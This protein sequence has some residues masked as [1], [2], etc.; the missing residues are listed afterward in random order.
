[1]QIE[2][3]AARL[4]KA[5]AEQSAAANAHAER[6][7]LAEVLGLRAE[8]LGVR[9]E[10]EQLQQMY[11]SVS[12]CL[13]GIYTCFSGL[14]PDSVLLLGVAS[15]WQVESCVCIDVNQS[16]LLLVWDYASPHMCARVYACTC[17]CQAVM[18]ACLPACSSPLP[19]QH[20][21]RH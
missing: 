9:A 5:L 7:M 20:S 12:V 11:Q 8:V 16:T 13:A 18:L 19:M 10:L 1:M 2:L 3:Q 17:T 21:S 4:E 6:D 14:D 15:G